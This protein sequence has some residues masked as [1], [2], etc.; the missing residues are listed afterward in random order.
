MKERA[1]TKDHKKAAADLLPNRSHATANISLLAHLQKLSTA[2]LSR[3]D[4]IGVCT[5]FHLDVVTSDVGFA[6]IFAATSLL[7]LSGFFC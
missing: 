3:T 4:F 2:T 5:E 1:T 6:A 7:I